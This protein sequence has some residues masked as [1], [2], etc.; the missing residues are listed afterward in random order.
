MTGLSDETLNAF[1]DG[2]LPPAEMRR[3]AAEVAG[4]ADLRDRL[5]RLAAADAAAR[6]RFA[7]ALREPVPLALARAVATAPPPRTRTGW[8]QTAAAAV[9][10]LVIGAGGTAWVVTGPAR[11]PAAPDW[12]AQVA[13]YHRIYAAEGRHLVEVGADETPHI[14]E[15]LAARIGRPFRVPDLTGDGFAFRGARLLVA[16][17]APV[18][19][20]VYVGED[21]AI[22]ALCLTARPGA[23]DAPPRLQEFGDLTATVWRQAGT[24]VVLVTPADLPGRDTIAATAQTALWQL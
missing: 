13:D 9:L 23:S 10:G 11:A 14:E 16:A 17:A 18:A 20:L 21:G 4:S 3:I 5:A 2:A 19:Q 6:D 12:V 8:R 24:A 1:H 7:A 15:W 22:I